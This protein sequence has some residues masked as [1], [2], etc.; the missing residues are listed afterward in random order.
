MVAGITPEG[1]GCVEGVLW[2]PTRT[3]AVWAA[4]MSV[5]QGI[6]AACEHCCGAEHMQWSGQEDG[7]WV[8]RTWQK[9]KQAVFNWGNKRAHIQQ[10]SKKNLGKKHPNLSSL[11]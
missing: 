3:D 2:D 11:I 6:P 8:Q 5:F 10:Y 7:S 9:M 4:G 1:E